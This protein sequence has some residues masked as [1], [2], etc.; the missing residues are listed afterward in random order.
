MTRR[1]GSGRCVEEESWARGMRSVLSAAFSPNGRAL[2]R[3][4]MTKPRGSGTSRRPRQVL[5]GHDTCVRIPSPTVVHVTA[6]GMQRGSGRRDGEGDATLR[7]TTATEVSVSAPT[8]RASSRR[9][10]TSSESGRGE[11]NEIATL[12]GTRR[13][14]GPPPS[15]PTG[16]TS[17]RRLM[18]RPRGSGTPRRRRRLRCRRAQRLCCVRCLQSRRDA[19]RH[20]VLGQDRADLGRRDGEGDHGAARR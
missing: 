13:F 1:R 4:P 11:G 10:M 18:T 6:F 19:H 15:A 5:R 20:G 14:C 2:S 9:W 7:G 16:R 12:R 8:G 3:R 17:S